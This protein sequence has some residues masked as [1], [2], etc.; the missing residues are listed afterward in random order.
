MVLEEAYPPS[1]KSQY[2][3]ATRLLATSQSLKKVV[4]P[5]SIAPHRP[6]GYFVL[7][8]GGDVP[9]RLHWDRLEVYRFL[10]QGTSDNLAGGR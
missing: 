2:D 8:R 3:F 7:S 1:L 6:T 9:R 10:L 4:L 5:F